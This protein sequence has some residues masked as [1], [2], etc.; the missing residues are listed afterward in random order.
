MEK[1]RSMELLRKEMGE[2]RGELGELSKE[3]EGL[4]GEKE[5]QC[6]QLENKYKEE[7]LSN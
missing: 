2:L 4:R 6:Q 7:S 3:V 1:D 5:R